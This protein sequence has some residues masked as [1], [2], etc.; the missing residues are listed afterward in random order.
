LT[1]GLTI[2]DLSHHTM[3]HES[4]PVL[5]VAHIHPA[6]RQGVARPARTLV[7]EVQAAI[8]AHKVVVV[9]MRHNPYCGKACKALDAQGV[10]YHALTYGNYWSGWRARN[11]LKMWTGWSTFP[12]VFVNGM[13]VGGFNDLT[14]LI[15]SGE[16]KQM[17]NP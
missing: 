14:A 16:L 8:Q 2:K 17:V 9:G 6:I 10:A 3:S 5:D 7:P 4:R 13:L 15:A 1:R 11:T 12:M